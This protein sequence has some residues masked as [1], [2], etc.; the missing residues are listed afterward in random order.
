MHTSVSIIVNARAAM[1]AGVA[2]DGC[3]VYVSTPLRIMTDAVSVVVAVASNV[4]IVTP[5][6][7]WVIVGPTGLVQYTLRHAVESARE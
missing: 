1:G 5:G 3:S 2:P 4:V 6:T 7:V